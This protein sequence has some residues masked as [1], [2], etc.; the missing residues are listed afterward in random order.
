MT[1]H[2]CN[3]VLFDGAWDMDHG[4]A[5][6]HYIKNNCVFIYSNIHGEMVSS[7][8]D[9]SLYCFWLLAESYKTINQQWDLVSSRDPFWR[10]SVSKVSGLDSVSVTKATGLGH[11]PIVLR[12]WISQ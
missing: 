1:N 9:D 10:V 3:L 4:T 8:C 12:L 5:A 2:L 11:K 6:H 7:L